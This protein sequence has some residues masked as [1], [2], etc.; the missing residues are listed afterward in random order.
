MIKSKKGVSVIIGYVLLV[1]LAIVMGGIMYAWMKSYVPKDKLECP[2]GTAILLNSY[3][4]NCT[5]NILTLSIKNNGRFGIAGYYIHASNTTN[6]T[7][8]TLDLS[9][10]LIEVLPNLTRFSNAVMFGLS[11]NNSFSPGDETE[12]S[13]NTASF[14]QISKIEIIPIRW[15]SENNKIKFVSC[16]STSTLSQEILCTS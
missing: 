12:N 14:G 4:Y 1:S 11:S 6:A 13:F 15:Q 10:A 16:G 3:D 9:K 8:P 7:L 2:E 5:E